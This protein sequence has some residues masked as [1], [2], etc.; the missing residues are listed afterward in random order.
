MKCPPPSA[1]PA[2]YTGKLLTVSQNLV[3]YNVIFRLNSLEREGRLS[4]KTLIK[5]KCPEAQLRTLRLWTDCDI[6]AAWLLRAAD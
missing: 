6:L 3:Y 1:A 2:Q 5:L 4:G